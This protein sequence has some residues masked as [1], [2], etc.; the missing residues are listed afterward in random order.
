MA[1]SFDAV[2]MLSLHESCRQ[3]L[4][5]AAP[6][7]PLEIERQS[8]SS[9]LTPQLLN[10]NLPLFGQDQ[11]HPENSASS[12]LR[13]M[14]NSIVQPISDD[15]TNGR[16]RI[17]RSSISKASI[18]NAIGK[19]AKSL[20]RSLRGGAVKAGKTVFEPVSRGVWALGRYLAGL[21]TSFWGQTGESELSTHPT[22]RKTVKST[23]E[24]SSFIRSQ[25]QSRKVGTD[26]SEIISV[27]VH[28]SRK[29]TDDSKRV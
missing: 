29:S 2:R 28:A 23:A 16:R 17:H 11:Q 21:L 26:N 4:S 15:N 18:T 22:P 6:S 12:Y 19:F 3:L 8:S 9:P 7:N 13:A 10:F 1:A 25:T 14:G 20:V 5:P 24:A 27:A